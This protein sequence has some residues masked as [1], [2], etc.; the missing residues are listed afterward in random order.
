MDIILVN[1]NNIT[2]ISVAGLQQHIGY[3][4]KLFESKW[5][6]SKDCAGSRPSLQLRVCNKKIF[7]LFLNKKYQCDG[8]FEHPKHMLKQMGK[9]IF[10]IT[11]CTSVFIFIVVESRYLDSHKP[12]IHCDCEFSYACTARYELHSGKTVHKDNNSTW[13]K[14]AE[15]RQ[16]RKCNLQNKQIRYVLLLFTNMKKAKAIWLIYLIVMVAS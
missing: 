14:M 15:K 9:N 6:D 12:E 8:S 7:F 10:T 3:A 2:I 5:E 13:Y 4:E 11:P 16:K 1:N